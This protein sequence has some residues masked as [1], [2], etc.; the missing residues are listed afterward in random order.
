MNIYEQIVFNINDNSRLGK[1]TDHIDLMA[2]EL[3]ELEKCC[4]PSLRETLPGKLGIFPIRIK[5]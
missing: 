4:P 5:R 2:K 1:V 3:N